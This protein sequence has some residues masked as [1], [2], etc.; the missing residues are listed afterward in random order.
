MTPPVGFSPFFTLT[1]VPDPANDEVDIQMCN[2]AP[3]GG[4][5]DPD[6]TGGT[7]PILVIKP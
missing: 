1:G 3:A 6:G 4:A 7:Y 5:I 2:H